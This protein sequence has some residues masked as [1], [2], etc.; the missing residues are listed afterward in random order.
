[1]PT[2]PTCR[3]ILVPF[4]AYLYIVC[5]IKFIDRMELDRFMYKITF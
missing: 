1:M 2:D 5:V 3:S 4:F